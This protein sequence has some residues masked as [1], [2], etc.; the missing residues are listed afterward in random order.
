MVLYIPF[1][2]YNAENQVWISF[3]NRGGV[4]TRTQVLFKMCV[5]GAH[6]QHSMAQLDQKKISTHG[7]L[8]SRAQRESKGPRSMNFS[9]WIHTSGH[10]CLHTSLICAY[11]Y[12]TLTMYENPNLAQTNQGR[13]TRFCSARHA[14]T[15]TLCHDQCFRACGSQPNLH[16]TG[17]VLTVTR[18]YFRALMFAFHVR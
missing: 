11:M 4:R 7:F 15:S 6:D 14:R 18:K 8:H 3:S 16:N 17:A 12:T 9:A 5:R 2:P 13:L 1:E 10:A